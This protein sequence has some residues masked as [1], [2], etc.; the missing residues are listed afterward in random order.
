MGVST[1]HRTNLSMWIL[2]YSFSDTYYV[3][4]GL[5]FLR[6]HFAGNSEVEL[7][8]VRFFLRLCIGYLYWMDTSAMGSKGVHKMKVYFIS[9]V[10][11]EQKQQGKSVNYE[12]W[13]LFKAIVGVHVT[14]VALLG[15]VHMEGW[16]TTTKKAR[17]N[18]KGSWFLKVDQ[19]SI[20]Y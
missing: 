6:C 2:I 16:G 14:T 4:G 8:K 17:V 20:G 15:R 18:F 12:R 3:Y 1:T 19:M 5:W 13:R 10:K 9:L 7:G 11:E